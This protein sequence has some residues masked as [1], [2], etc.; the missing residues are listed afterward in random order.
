MRS[1][2]AERASDVAAPVVQRAREA[3]GLLRL[4]S[5]NVQALGSFAAGGDWATV[6]PLDVEQTGPFNDGDDLGRVVQDEVEV[7]FVA[8]PVGDLANLS[9]G[10]EGEH[11]PAVRAQGSRE[12]SDCGWQLGRGEV[13]E[14][15]PR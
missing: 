10:V 4:A 14:C 13:D 8:E 11:E 12:R 2:G 7:D 3:M 1:R 6:V 9:A 5:E 15:V